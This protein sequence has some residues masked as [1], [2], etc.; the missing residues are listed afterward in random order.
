MAFESC[1]TKYIHMHEY[2]FIYKY[3]YTHTQVVKHD[4]GIHMISINR[5]GCRNYQ[6][7]ELSTLLIN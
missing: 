4:A 6:A 3:A 5:V 7:H 1:G 2:V